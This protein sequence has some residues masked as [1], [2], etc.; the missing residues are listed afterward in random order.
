MEKLVII[1]KDRQ[2]TLETLEG[3]LEDFPGIHYGFSD[4][5]RNRDANSILSRFYDTY[6]WLLFYRSEHEP[7][8]FVMTKAARVDGQRVMV[9][10]TREQYLEALVELGYEPTEREERSEL[11]PMDRFQMIAF[12]Q[13]KPCTQE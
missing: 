12:N 4:E 9:S 7:F 6:P 3:I 5:P 8:E 11:P 2:E 10:P 1:C 13:G